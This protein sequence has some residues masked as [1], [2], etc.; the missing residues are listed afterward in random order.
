MKL[1]GASPHFRHRNR[2]PH[3]RTSRDAVIP[4]FW[5]WAENFRPSGHTAHT[6][7][8]QPGEFQL[9]LVKPTTVAP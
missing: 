2:Q 6:S 7:P 1:R 9:V 3:G 5:V 4:S 8:Q